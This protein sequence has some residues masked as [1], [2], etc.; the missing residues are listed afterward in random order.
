MPG[1]LPVVGRLE[2]QLGLVDP[3]LSQGLA[4]AAEQHDANESARGM[5]LGRLDTYC[6]EVSRI[7][8][9]LPH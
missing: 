2:M 3:L 5:A 8:P 7:A 9:V 4:A 6:F 1:H